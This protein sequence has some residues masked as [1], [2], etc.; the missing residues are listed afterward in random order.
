M[1]Y[2]QKCIENKEM[3]I[4]CYEKQKYNSFVNR[5]YY[6]FYQALL[7]KLQSR[8]LLKE[9]KVLEAGSHENTFYLFEQNFV[10][11]N[12]KFKWSELRTLKSLFSEIKSAR[13]KADYNE[14]SISK[15]E[16]DGIIRTYTNLIE[17]LNKYWGDILWL[18]N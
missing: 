4:L 3:G 2:E 5:Y 16:A 1:S 8:D 9:I 17:C 12:R 6:S 15:E 7:L 18:M 11:K 13:Q 10:R 14:E